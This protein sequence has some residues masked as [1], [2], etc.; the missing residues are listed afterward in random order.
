MR[1]FVFILSHSL[2]WFLGRVFE[3]F[4][5]TNIFLFFVT[6]LHIVR[7]FECAS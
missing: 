7:F 1:T 4:C 6:R 5:D 2:A 3:F